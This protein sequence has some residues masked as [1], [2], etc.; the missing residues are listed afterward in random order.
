MPYRRLLAFLAALAAFSL[1]AAAC[2]DDGEAETAPDDS[3]TEE[4]EPDP[5]P[6]ERDRARGRTGA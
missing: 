4:P 1:V 2:G 3:V 6:D 5:E